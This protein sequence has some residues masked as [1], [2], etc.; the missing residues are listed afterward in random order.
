[1]KGHCD[2]NC[3][4]EGDTPAAYCVSL[5]LDVRKCSE[6]YC[7]NPGEK[8]V[9]PGSAVA[10]PCDSSRDGIRKCEWI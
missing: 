6:N 9:D 5:G 8:T 4:R 3:H 7:R 1:M 10:L 2:P